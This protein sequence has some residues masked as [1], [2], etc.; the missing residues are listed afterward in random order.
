LSAFKTNLGAVKARLTE[1]CASFDVYAPVM[2][3]DKL[4][5]TI[6]S[7]GDDA[8]F[9]DELPYKSPKEAAFPQFEDV[10]KFTGGEVRETEGGKPA[11]VVFAKPCDVAAFSV[12]DAVFTGERGRFQDYYY[13]KRRESL[14]VI[15][16]AC[17]SMK[18]GCFCDVRGIDMSS[19]AGCDG[20]FSKDADGSL[21]YE[22]LTQKG[23]GVFTGDSH[24]TA[25]DDGSRAADAVLTI[26]AE[27]SDV[28]EKMPWADY[29]LGCLGCGICTYICPTC[30]CFALRDAEEHGDITRTRVWDS[31]MYPN[32][33]LHA[34]GHNPRGGKAERFRQRVLHKYLY[35]PE[36][37]GTTACTGC[38]RCVRSCPGGLNIRRTVE[39]I[40]GRLE[41]G[42]KDE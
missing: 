25:T 39:D 11:L 31:C 38:G 24:V 13:G 34:S 20:F 28:F 17:E 2:S 18:P 6:I 22:A 40:K 29:A 4:E 15:G 5:Y 8:V 16:M 42:G 9:S 30:H 3:A 35:I 10:M 41:G 27:E 33:T 7:S 1:L 14:V 26:D 37:F 23:E 21:I 12:L 19:A 32:F 36:N